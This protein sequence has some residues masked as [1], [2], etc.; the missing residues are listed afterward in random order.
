[1]KDMGDE[2]SEFETTE[3]EI[4]G[5]MAAGEPVQVDVPGERP[6]IDSL[7]VA[8]VVPLTRGGSSITPNIGN[9]APSVRVAMPMRQSSETAA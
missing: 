7:Y 4:D 3:D 9:V 6:Y 1:M 2:F 5:M 8:A